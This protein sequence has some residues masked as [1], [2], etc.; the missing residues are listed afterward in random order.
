METSC[1]C[2]FCRRPCKN[3]NS[4]RNHERLCKLNPDFD[5][6]SY[7]NLMNG[8]KSYR[9]KLSK[10]EMIPWNK[11]KSK[12]D[13]PSLKTMSEKI[14]GRPSIWKGKHH[15]KRYDNSKGLSGG[16]RHGAGRGKK[17]RYRG[18][19]CDSSWELAYLIYCLEHGIRIERCNE[20]FEYTF[21][22]QKHK[23]FPDFIVDGTYIEIKG[24][25][26]DKVLAKIEQF[27]KDRSYKVLHKADLSS[28]FS[29]VKGKYGE[30]FVKLYEKS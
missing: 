1:I 24:F 4:Q 19:W 15:L 27:P 17:G 5:K 2:K 6:S 16:L 11:G 20:S 30:D 22:N 12:D 26:T 21:E 28:V 7:Q 25:D 23:Y 3:P 10:G 18:F 29:Y 8:T 9:D 13:D 14:K